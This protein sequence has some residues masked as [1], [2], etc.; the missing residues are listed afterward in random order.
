M[1]VLQALSTSNLDIRKKTIDIA[2]DLIT[3]RNLDEVVM[4]LKKEVVKTQNLEHEKN[5]EYRQMLVQAIHS[6]AIKFPEVASTELHLLMDFLGN[7]NVASAIDVVVFVREIIETNPKLRVSIITRLLDT[8]YQIR[9]ARVCSCALWIIGEYCLPLSKVEIGIAM[10]KQ[11]LGEL[12]LFTV[13]EEGE[14]QDQGAKKVQQV[15][16][17]TVSSRR[18]AILADGTY[19]TQSAA[20]ETAMSPPTFVQGSLSFVVF[21]RKLEIIDSIG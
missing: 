5:G 16:S 6:C 14:V 2:L 17:T 13:T 18:P 12:P 11:C 9:A 8:F 10:I 7:S 15:N 21:N 19:A 3:S 20:L 1:D 4:M